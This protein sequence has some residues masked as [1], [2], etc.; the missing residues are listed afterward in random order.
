MGVCMCDAHAGPSDAPEA[1][2]QVSRLHWNAPLFDASRADGSVVLIVTNYSLPQ[3]TPEL[4]RNARLRI[5]ADGGANRLFDELP[6]LVPEQSAEQVRHGL[7]YNAQW[8]RSAVLR[9]K[10]V[11]VTC[12]TLTSLT[13]HR[14]APTLCLTS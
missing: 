11:T 5:A 12:T 3:C 9:P 6:R 14:L 1:G 8:Q 13:V 7:I 2:R 10:G 4:W